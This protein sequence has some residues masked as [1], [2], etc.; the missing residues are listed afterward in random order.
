MKI[1]PPSTSLYQNQ[2]E[3]PDALGHILVEVGVVTHMN[4]SPESQSMTGLSGEDR[5]CGKEQQLQSREKQLQEVA[6]KGGGKSSDL[7]WC[8]TVLT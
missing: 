3:M 4:P 5:V 6:M 2:K 7:L 1:D 8:V